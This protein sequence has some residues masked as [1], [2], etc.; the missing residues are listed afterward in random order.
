MYNNKQVTMKTI[1]FILIALL[2]NLTSCAQ[3]GDMEGVLNSADVDPSFSKGQEAIKISIKDNL[4]NLNLFEYAHSLNE[5]YELMHSNELS[6]KDWDY[7]IET[8]LLEV[9][10]A[11]KDTTPPFYATDYKGIIPLQAEFFLSSLEKNESLK[12]KYQYEYMSLK[13]S[14]VQ[15]L[16]YGYSR[17]EIDTLLILFPQSST[18]GTVNFWYFLQVEG[19]LIIKLGIEKIGTERMEML[20]G[21]LDITSTYK[22]PYHLQKRKIQSLQRRLSNCQ[23]EELESPSMLL[24]KRDIAIFDKDKNYFKDAINEGFNMDEIK[25]F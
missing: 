14:M 18:V 5:I 20:L 13:N 2:I 11:K 15:L 19:C 9:K 22:V 17:D 23:I 1:T 21:N 4:A 24:S 10:Q 16:D 8:L 3:K 6:V 12:S 25:D 7:Y